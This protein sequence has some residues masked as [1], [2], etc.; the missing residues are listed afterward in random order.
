[1]NSQHQTGDARPTIQVAVDGPS[2]SGK[3]T[4]SK[5]LAEQLGFI[6]VDSGSLYRAITWTANE[7]KIPLGDTAA[8]VSLLGALVAEPYLIGRDL[9]FKVNA[10]DPGD[11]LRS[12]AVVERVSDI[13]AVP[14]VRVFVVDRLREAARM[15][16][17]VMEGRDIGSV[18][19]PDT[20]FKFYLDADP[21]ERAR[22]RHA[23]RDSGSGRDGLDA[24]R[25][26]LDRRDRKDTSRETA[27]LQIPDG[28][29][30]INTTSLS[31]DEV[32]AQIEESIRK[33][34]PTLSK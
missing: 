27:P 33:E 6:Y 7:D 23:E 13:A 22:R 4:V 3:S 20:R 25:D 24:V 15:G 14:E 29:S 21:E 16:N 31:L 12:E 28:A 8:V 2:A 5:R 26:S 11:A 34:C 10:I 32:V 17:L 19:F 30:I 1:M 18:V 9:R